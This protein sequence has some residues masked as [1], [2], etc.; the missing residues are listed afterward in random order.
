MTGVF[1][2]REGNVTIEAEVGVMQPQAKE[3]LEPPEAGRDKDRSS[4]RAFGRSVAL[5]TPAFQTSGLQSCEKI[6]LAL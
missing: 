2:R 4:P 1:T 6:E 5:P 3:C